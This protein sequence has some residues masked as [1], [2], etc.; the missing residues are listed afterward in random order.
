MEVLLERKTAE[1]C[2]LNLSYNALNLNAKEG[3]ELEDGKVF[4]LKLKQFLS[5]SEKLTHLELSGMNI[6]ENV[7]QILPEI[8]ANN[9]LRIV[10]LSNNLISKETKKFMFNQLMQ[11]FSSAK[12]D[13]NKSCPVKSLANKVTKVGSSAQMKAINHQM[14]KKVT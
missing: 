13:Q 10:H 8:K 6:G 5:T 3:S 2:D 4:I 14:I 7:L 1:I 11:D 9:H 12:I